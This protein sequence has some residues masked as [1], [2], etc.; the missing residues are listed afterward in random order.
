MFI[1]SIVSEMELESIGT[2]GLWS[3]ELES[4]GTSELL[5]KTT[6]GNCHQ[7]FGIM[8]HNKQDPHYMGTV[9]F[10]GSQFPQLCR[11]RMDEVSLL[12]ESYPKSFD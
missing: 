10:R 7:C 1:V 8:E 2:S 12:M 6:N 3:K 5:S 4:I 9:V 11:L